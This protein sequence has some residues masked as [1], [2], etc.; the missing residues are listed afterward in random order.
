MSSRVKGKVFTRQ[1]YRASIDIAGICKHIISFILNCFSST[2]E[3]PR[4]LFFGI[5]HP[6]KLRVPLFLSIIGIVVIGISPIK[7]RERGV[8]G[9]PQAK[10]LLDLE[11]KFIIRTILQGLGLVQAKWIKSIVHKG[12]RRKIILTM[13]NY[14]CDH[15]HVRCT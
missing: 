14:A 4:K 8:K 1:L 15:H 6:L 12:R 5:G 7:K 3:V 13:S 11:L 9:C 2:S 10:K